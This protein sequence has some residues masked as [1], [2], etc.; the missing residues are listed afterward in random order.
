MAKLKK[1]YQCEH[2]GFIS[3]KWIGKCPD[4]NSW[5]SFIEG[6][7]DNG[8]K[9]NSLDN[10][11]AL[12]MPLNDIVI[13]HFERIKTRLNEIDKL[14]GGG[15]VPG[16]VIIT[17]G[18]PGIGKSTLIL[19]ILGEL[20]KQNI[21]SLY[22]CGEES[23]EQIKIRAERLKINGNSI[24]LSTEIEVK[25]IEQEISKNNYNILVVDS[26]QT[27]YNNEIES[28][29]GSLSQIKDCTFHLV[30]LAKKRHLPII[31]IGHITKDGQIAGPKVLEHMVDVVLYFEGEQLR[32]LRLIRSV[33]NRFGTIN[34]LALFQMSEKGL[35]EEK[36]LASFFFSNESEN[37]VALTCIKEGSR[38]L[39]VEIQAL[40]SKANYG[41]PQRVTNGYD[42]K[43]LSV[44][45][46]V[47]EKKAALFLGDQDVFVKVSSALRISDP[48]VDMAVA[49]AI[50]SSFA[51]K[52]FSEKIVFCGELSLTGSFQAQIQ[53][54]DKVKECK[55]YSINHFACSNDEKNIDINLK[56]V[57]N[58]WDL[59]DL[60]MNN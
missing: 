1:Q 12:T 22:I 28:A 40:V 10:E 2:C 33:K 4:C 55:K 32:D 16:S 38:Y 56:S 18:S 29:P 20:A 14:L 27:I 58:I 15:I 47:L 54:R 17:G 60:L 31:I 35:T 59:N 6:I 44:I 21:R 19:Q 9:K 8:M 41:M 26:I 50:W 46:A 37:G 39:V 45:L 51:N 42:Q 52:K 34:E 49:A 24:V 30:K 48:S 53:I 13:E 23:P 57:K 3:A 5:N 25:R 43:R 36:D 7:V 11:K